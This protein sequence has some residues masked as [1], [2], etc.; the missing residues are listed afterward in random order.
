MTINGPLKTMP[1]DSCKNSGFTLIE[2]SIVLVIV[3]TLTVPLIQA[4][5]A[6]LNEEK[7]RI[8]K[9]NIK[10][11][12][13]AMAASDPRYAPCPSDRSIPFGDPNY[14]LE[15]CDIA[16]IPDCNPGGIPAQGICRVRGSR[17]TIN[18]GASVNDWIIIGGVPTRLQPPAP[19]PEI[20]ILKSEN[21]LDGW[22]HVLNYAV[23][24]KVMDHTNTS[25]AENYKHGAIN[26]QD[27]NG[28]PT[29][30]V[31]SPKGDAQFVVWS[32]GANGAGAYSYTGLEISPCPN[33][34]NANQDTENCDNDNTFTQGIG[35][36]EGAGAGYFDD[37]SY[38]YL[39]TSG[40]LWTY[41]SPR[42]VGAP[43]QHI[44]NLNTDKVVISNSPTLSPEA[45][46][47]LYKLW[48]EGDI[49]A[50]TVLAQTY[51][52]S[53]TGTGN[54]SPDGFGLNADNMCP[55]YNGQRGI[56]AGWTAGTSQP[57][58]IP[59]T[60]LASLFLSTSSITV[61]CP[62]GSWVQGFTTKFCILC[63]NG[64]E[65]CPP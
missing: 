31:A 9:E 10:I 35:N 23:S 1:L 56:L 16:T 17:D 38:F 45:N 22:G 13:G 63:S 4:Y 64:T 25:G 47:P 32:S 57:S 65:Q 61:S 44:Y 33:G 59:G 21:A 46:D 37:T 52:T 27:E 49:S 34:V 5:N 20:R 15:R 51:K 30:G 14:G 54:P 29:A 19:A 8:T 6:Y 62:A 3:A 53:S 28:N 48:V 26:A 12:T 43:A 36:Y 60:Y 18:D 58:C 11:T 55:L 40:D 41:A 42:T 50:A 2:M 24:E 7:I 39:Q